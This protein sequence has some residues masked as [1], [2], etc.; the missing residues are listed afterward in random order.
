MERNTVNIDLEDYNALLIKAEKYDKL[1][2]SKKSEFGSD[3]DV[4]ASYSPD[5][6]FIDVEGDVD[7]N[8]FKEYKS[9]VKRMVINFK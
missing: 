5:N 2:K 4:I 6:C 3:Y 9:C 8:K 1:P 7:F